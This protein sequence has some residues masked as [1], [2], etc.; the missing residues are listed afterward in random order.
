MA[1]EVYIWDAKESRDVC[2]EILPTKEYP[3]SVHK[4]STYGSTTE[5]RIQS[6]NE[7]LIGLGANLVHVSEWE[8]IRI[9][10]QARKLA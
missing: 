4:L 7:V 9:R 10:S 1:K 3:G 2:Y 5:E 6:L 8:M